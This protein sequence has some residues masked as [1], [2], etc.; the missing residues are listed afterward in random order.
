MSDARPVPSSRQ[1]AKPCSPAQVPAVAPEAGEGGD[2]PPVA[3]EVERCDA[4]HRC[5]MLA[6]VRVLALVTLPAVAGYLLGSIP[7]ADLVSGPI[8][9]RDVGDRN[10]GY[11]N[12]R[13][14]LGSKAALP[15]LVGD[16]G[17]GIAAAAVGRA[18]AG[19]DQSWPAVVGAGA[20]MVGHA[21]PLFA[22]FRGGRAVAT[23]IGAAAVLSPPATALAMVA[24]GA[25]FVARRSLAPAVH[26]SFVAYPLAQLAIDGPRRTAATG[27]LMSFIG[28]RFV[29]ASV[30]AAPPAPPGVDDTSRQCE[31]GQRVG[32]R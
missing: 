26:A 2:R 31:H 32:Q 22:H 3:H 10:P 20:A 21:W 4:G 9:L 18:I 12:A 6:P 13:Q 11:W 8:D 27:L 25:T 17:K 19:R 29:M 1:N 28:V 24:G 14:A 5:D 16:V 7:S 15:V 23:F 30:A